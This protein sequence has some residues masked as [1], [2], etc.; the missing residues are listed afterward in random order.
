MNVEILY[1]R[2]VAGLPGLME[3]STDH[4]RLRRRPWHVWQIGVG[5]PCGSS[6]AAQSARFV[7]PPTKTW[8]YLDNIWMYC[9]SHL[10]RAR[11][12]RG[13]HPRGTGRAHCCLPFRRRIC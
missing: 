8:L 10:S 13:G 3:H 11:R 7:D 5:V 6:A 1:D 12:L 2:D 4:G 9:L